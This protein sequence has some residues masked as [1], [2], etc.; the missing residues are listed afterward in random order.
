MD[1]S[2]AHRRRGDANDSSGHV[3]RDFFRRQS[4]RVET[5]GWVVN[6]ARATR[7]YDA[8]HCVI[9]PAQRTMV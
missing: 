4:R 9:V 6:R 8:V 2:I 7:P 3:A 1:W 5:I